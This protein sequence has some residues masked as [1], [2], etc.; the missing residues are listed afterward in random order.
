MDYF[1]IFFGGI[2][3]LPAH[4]LKKG[5]AL[6]TK[7]GVVV[8]S[9][10]TSILI[11]IANNDQ[12]QAVEDQ[13]LIV[14]EIEGVLNNDTDD[15][16]VSQLSVSLVTAPGQGV[17][18]LQSN[19][20][21][22][23]LPPANF[24]GLVSFTYQAMD[25]NGA[26]SNV[27]TVEINVQPVN[28][29]PIFSNIPNVVVLDQRDPNYE[30]DFEILPGPTKD[31]NPQSIGAIAQNTNDDLITDLTLIYPFSLSGFDGKLQFNLTGESGRTEILISAN[32]SA[33]TEMGGLEV[34]TFTLEVII[35]QTIP[36]AVNDTFEVSEDQSLIGNILTNDTD[37]DTDDESLEVDITQ[38]VQHGVLTI[39]DDGSFTY[40]PNENFS[41]EDS[42]T[43]SLDDET[44]VSDPATVFITV[45][46]VNDPPIFAELPDTL[47]INQNAPLQE[48]DFRIAAGPTD[49][50]SQNVSLQVSASEPGLLTDLEVDPQA[51]I[52]SQLRFRPTGVPG[53][54]IL[55]VRAQDDAGVDLGGIDTTCFEIYVII[56]QNVPLGQDDNY[57]LYEEQIFELQDSTILDNDLDEDSEVLTAQLVTDV[58]HGTLLLNTD[59][60]F[61]YT[62][63]V[64]FNGVDQFTYQAS[65]GENLSDEVIVTLNIL[66]VND[67]PAFS[68]PPDSLF[69]NQNAG[70]FSFYMVVNSGPS[71]EITQ[72]LSLTAQS[73]HA[74]LI[75]IIQVSAPTVDSSEVQIR[76]IGQPGDAQILLSLQDD[77]G[78][79][80]GGVDT[81]QIIIPIKI[82]QNIPIARIDTFDLDEDMVFNAPNSVLEND[83][84]GDTSPDNLSAE[85]VDDAS[86]G[87]LALSL[88]VFLPIHQHWTLMDRIVL[89]IVFLIQKVMLIP[90]A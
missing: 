13:L 67:P 47:K 23:Y 80:M 28:D 60:T 49:E 72:S 18:D 68:N 88:D 24:N 36:I 78:T 82:I 10:Y 65:D 57:T 26:L 22:S 8:I 40:T 83:Q 31:E 5:Y 85:L 37:D 30:L 56:M 35:Q 74:E 59:G 86:Q 58:Q 4:T 62:P 66:P 7:S 77:G 16:S 11:P 9:K 20:A 70:V 87:S 3:G 54:L 51:G 39:H 81:N 25:G 89:L 27:A 76:V 38:T 90:Q 73:L 53:T 44:D 33:G 12:Y 21:F 19:G 64:D 32:D 15:G 43:Y 79:D 29:P 1:D 52:N 17:L 61:N 34:S 69:V 84:D 2:L 75:E 71:N 6:S 63:E 41:G 46:P 50:S 45:I 14:S 55:K 42:F 48:I